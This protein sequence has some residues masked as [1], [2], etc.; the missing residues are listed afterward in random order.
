MVYKARLIIPLVAFNIYVVKGV[1][2]H[3]SMGNII[4]GALSYV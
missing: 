3:V 1:A 4:R 2:T